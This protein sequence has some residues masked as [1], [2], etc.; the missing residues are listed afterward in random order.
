MEENGYAEFV[1]VDTTRPIRPGETPG[2]IYI[3]LTDED[4]VQNVTNNKY[5]D[6]ETF[7]TVGQTVKT[8]FGDMHN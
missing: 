3:Y 2:K 4:F 6:G 1:P 8:L 7:F 5:F